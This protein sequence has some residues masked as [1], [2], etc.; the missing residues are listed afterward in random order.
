[1]QT[2]SKNLATLALIS[3]VLL[4]A[5]ALVSQ[6]FA[7]LPRTLKFKPVEFKTP[8]VDSLVFPN[9]LHGYILEDHEIPVINIVIMFRTTYP[10]P[11]KTGLNQL[12]GWAIRN[13]GSK[14]FSKD[15]IDDELEYV[16]A[17]IE[18]YCGDLVG[19][20]EANFLTKDTDKVLEILADLIINP[21][22]EPDKI[23]LRKNT[24]IESIRRKADDPNALGAR[25]FSK[26]VYRGHPAGLEPTVE[27]VE[28]LTRDDVV[29]FHE[30]YVKPD[31]AVIGISGDMTKEQALEI[32]SDLLAEWKPGGKQPEVPEMTYEL[33]PSVN[34]I[35][36][37]VNQAYI[38]AGHMAVNSANPDV[39]YLRIMNYILGGGSFTSWITQRIRSDEG[40]AYS[41][42][43]RFGS[44]PWGYGLFRASCQTRTDA[45]ARALTLLIEQIERMKNQGPTE[46]EVEK[47]KEALVNQQVFEYESSH[48]VIRKLIWFDICALPL[49]TIE[50]Y[51]KAYQS[52]TV[53][54]IKR[55]A[56]K[57]LHPEGLTI[58]VVGD[59]SRFDRPLSDF[60]E[61]N[62]I[63]IEE[64][65]ME[66]KEAQ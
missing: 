28:N 26:L 55:V 43:S 56:R 65:T 34:Y 25:E 30:E 64:T 63:E 66:R 14:N 36:K 60:G 49:D 41:A 47:A 12:A 10:P 57:Y 45:A 6:S 4:I 40:L 16:G 22:F 23:E 2:R 5:L 1:M 52:A 62:V 20:I 33:N 13:G 38:F 53:E 59:Q 51:F 37:D 3:L 29:R 21:A 19:T 15:Q 9:G 31:N 17:S 11:D 50:R 35:Y 48:I 54:D 7:R 39:P 42:G 18:T 27:T 32:L 44:S 8:E 24:M 61:V 58:L 46:E